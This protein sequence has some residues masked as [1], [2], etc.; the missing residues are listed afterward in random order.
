MPPVFSA[1][2]PDLSSRA[3]TRYSLALGSPLCVSLVNRC[4]DVRPPHT[5]FASD[6]AECLDPHHRRLQ[7]DVK[8]RVKATAGFVGYELR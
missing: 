2:R 8:R 7:A 3:G 6:R 5:M 4:A 1:M